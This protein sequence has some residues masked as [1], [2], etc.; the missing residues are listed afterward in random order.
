MTGPFPDGYLDRSSSTEAVKA[1]ILQSAAGDEALEVC[2]KSM[3]GMC[4][5]SESKMKGNHSSVFRVI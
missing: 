2:K 1:A 3:K 5:V 4:Y